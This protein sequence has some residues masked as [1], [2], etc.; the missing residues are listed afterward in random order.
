MADRQIT[1]TNKN[2]GKIAVL[3]DNADK[4]EQ[5]HNK[6]KDEEKIYISKARP[7]VTIQ[8]KRFDY[9]HPDKPDKLQ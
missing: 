4:M 5:S 3:D 1:T 8:V 6:H 2:N 9:C 7:I